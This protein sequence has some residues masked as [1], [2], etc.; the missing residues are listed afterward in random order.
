MVAQGDTVLVVN[1]LGKR[2]HR[3]AAGNRRRSDYYGLQPAVPA[4]FGLRAH[5]R[6]VRRG[7]STADTSATSASIRIFVLATSM[8]LGPDHFFSTQ[9]DLAG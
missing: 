9:S 8:L 7:C 3:K 4:V 2:R 1:D 6:E 5:P